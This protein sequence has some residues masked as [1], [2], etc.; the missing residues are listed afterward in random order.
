MTMNYVLS[1]NFQCVPMGKFV[2]KTFNINLISPLSILTVINYISL[3]V[4]IQYTL[5]ILYSF[6]RIQFVC[7]CISNNNNDLGTFE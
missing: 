3:S 4:Y 1:T 5:N 6:E 2:A 7:D